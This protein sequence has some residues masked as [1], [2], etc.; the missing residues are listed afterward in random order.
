M[1]NKIEINVINTNARSLRPK[2]LSFINAFDEMEA[3][4]AI[5]TETWFTEND[6]LQEDMQDLL[7]GNGMLGFTKNREAGAAGFAHGGVAIICRNSCTKFKSLNF[8][9]PDNFEVLAITGVIQSI[10]RN[11]AIVGVYVPPNYNTPRAKACLQHVN[12]LV[13]SIKSRFQDPFICIGGDFNQWKPEEAL[14]DY[15]DMME[16]FSPPTRG[17]RRIDRMFTNWSDCVTDSGCL[18]PLE[19]EPD[20]NGTSTRSDHAIQYFCSRIERKEPVQWVEYDYRPLNPANSAAFLADLALED[21]SSVSGSYGSNAKARAYQNIIDHLMD[22]HFP[23]VHV[24]KRESDPP[25]VEQNCQKNDQEEESYL[26]SRGTL[27]E[28]VEVKKQTR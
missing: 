5:V 9:N 20:Q 16:I 15:P 3:T 22:A 13:L 19:S 7:L 21:W 25:M 2:L 8:P 27:G 4:V 12:D 11:F 1:D 14:V 28:V 23:I 18:P 6:K 17:A 10:K 24:R 26:Q